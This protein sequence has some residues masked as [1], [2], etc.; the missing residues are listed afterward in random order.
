MA[1]G[2]EPP[3]TSPKRRTLSFAQ[4]KHTTSPTRRRALVQL[5]ESVGHDTVRLIGSLEGAA[6]ARVEVV[7]RID[8]FSGDWIA[9][10]QEFVETGRLPKL[11]PEGV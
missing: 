9:L 8:D 3:S 10:L 1:M 6:T 11:G 7:L 5:I 2:A 4:A